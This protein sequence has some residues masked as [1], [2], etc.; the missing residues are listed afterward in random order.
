MRLSAKNIYGWSPPSEV[1]EIAAAGVP[2]QMA[3]PV[4]QIDP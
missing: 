3:V 2:E 4:T 1:L